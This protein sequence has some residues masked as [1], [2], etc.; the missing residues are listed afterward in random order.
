MMVVKGTQIEYVNKSFI[1]IFGETK[2]EYIARNLK[3]VV[4]LEIL[5]VFENLLQEDGISKELKFRGKEFIVYSFVI[6]K[7]EEEEGKRLG[8]MLQDISE[9][10]KSEEKLKEKIE[11]LERYKKL[12]VDR[13]LKMIE[14]KKRIEKF[15]GR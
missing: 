4:P 10:K 9:R 8:I 15:E 3:D 11:E 14:L 1:S 7:A 12:T 2:N 5:S 13:E 6:K